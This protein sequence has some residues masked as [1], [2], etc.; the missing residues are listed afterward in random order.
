MRYILL[1]LI[2]TILSGCARRSRPDGGPKDED[3]PIM[4]KAKPDFGSTHFNA[5]EIKIF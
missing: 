1:I 4:V 5:D 3:K 2:F